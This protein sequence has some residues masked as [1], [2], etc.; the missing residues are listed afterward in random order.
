M[1]KPF[2][3][4]NAALNVIRACLAA[5]IFIS[6]FCYFSSADRSNPIVINFPSASE[7]E[8]TSAPDISSTLESLH[9]YTVIHPEISTY[10]EP[11]SAESEQ[12]FSHSSNEYNDETTAEEEPVIIETAP[13]YNISPPTTAQTVPSAD[14]ASPPSVRAESTAELININEAS[15]NELVRLNGIGEVKAA[16]IV[17]YRRTNGN[18]SAI[19]DIM[20]VKGIGEKTFEK[21]RDQ[22]SV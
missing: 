1:K 19:E 22:I 4:T 14:Y 7:T 21:I 3:I 18:F 15:V 2:S 17:E 10:T 12:T 11:L 6:L 9:T 5:G 16:A 13:E 8:E 20:K